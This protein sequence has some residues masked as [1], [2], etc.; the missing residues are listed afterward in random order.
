MK[1]PP[2]KE[3]GELMKQYKISAY[4]LHKELNT[5]DDERKKIG[6]A[7]INEIISGKKTKNPRYLTMVT[8]FEVVNEIIQK[9]ENEKPNN[10][11]G[12]IGKGPIIKLKIGDSLLRAN[13]LLDEYSNEISTFPIFDGD[14][15]KGIITEKS[16]RITMAKHPTNWKK[17]TVMEA[18]DRRPPIVDYHVPVKVLEKYL[19][20]EPC[21]LVRNK[22]GNSIE[23]II[24]DHDVRN[25]HAKTKLV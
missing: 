9:E 13:N 18:K 10:L 23:K 24:T 17:L 25:R 15:V 14:E 3:L 8:L 2:I 6:M 19:D 7:T 22:S 5:K 21:V 4:R 12:E 20:D 11:A 1:F 16:L